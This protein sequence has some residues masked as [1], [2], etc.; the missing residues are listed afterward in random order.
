MYTCVHACTLRVVGAPTILAHGTCRL[1]ARIFFSS[2]ALGL[3][4]SFFCYEA[5]VETIFSAC[6]TFLALP[7]QASNNHDFPLQPQAVSLLR[8]CC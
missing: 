5:L 3:T 4:F 7:L 2:T 1:Y 6:A 8:D